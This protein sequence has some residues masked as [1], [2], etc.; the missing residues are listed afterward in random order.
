MSSP[1]SLPTR[2]E[3]L[4]VDSAANGNEEIS[5]AL[6]RPDEGWKEK[7]AA[8][9]RR[10]YPR[11]VV[12]G[13]AELEALAWDLDD[14]EAWPKDPQKATDPATRG[15][16]GDS[17]RF[18][19]GRV[20]RSHLDAVRVVKVIAAPAAAEGDHAV[21]AVSGS[22][23]CTVKIW[24]DLI[25]EN[26]YAAALLYRYIGSRP[27]TALGVTESDATG[28]KVIVSGSLDST[29]CIWRYPTAE[30]STYDPVDE[31]VLLGTIETHGD[32]VWGIEPLRNDRFA[33]ITADGSVQIWEWPTCTLVRSWQYRA[34]NPNLRGSVSK[35][36][37]S[38][39]I[40]T[41]MA[42]FDAQDGTEQLV[43]AFQNGDIN[44]YDP[45][46]S[47]RELRTLVSCESA[48]GT[49]ER[50]INSLAVDLANL[51]LL[52][53]SEDRSISVFSLTDGSR[54]CSFTAHLDGV[55]SLASLS[56]D[57]LVSASHDTSIR[58][59]SLTDGGISEAT[60]A[61]SAR[62]IQDLQ[63]HQTK[64]AEGV[65]VVAMSAGHLQP[66]LVSAGADGTLRVW[67]SE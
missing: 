20:L 64:G 52:V 34:S 48:D 18:K 5:T 6:F 10:A 19:P 15:T 17:P 8:A 40:P 13:D 4:S 46:V 26:K 57:I 9:G 49:P 21:E 12:G 27:I 28:S 65:L 24:H 30:R 41:A 14:D 39:Q 58:I 23:D 51:R 7:L 36:P 47:E 63:A 11:A 53:G 59:W 55:T 60:D 29:V 42:L 25:G 62:C 66:V 61:A 56:S 43:V 45:K 38:V 3:E 54:L 22:D 32:A 50:Q 67:C 37:P 44:L 2:A 33:C 35:K 16:A 1:S 31:L